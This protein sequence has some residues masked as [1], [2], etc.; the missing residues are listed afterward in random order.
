MRSASGVS[1]ITGRVISGGDCVAM[2]VKPSN[3]QAAAI[4][5][6][7]N[8]IFMLPHYSVNYVV[9]YYPSISL[10]LRIRESDLR[11]GTGSGSEPGSGDPSLP[12]PGTDRTPDSK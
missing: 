9:S 10:Q 6:T 1:N 7:V 2:T 5:T 12:R 11:Y 8:E 3:A 4:R